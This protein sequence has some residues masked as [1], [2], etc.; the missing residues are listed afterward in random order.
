MQLQEEFTEDWSTKSSVVR[1][2]E[3]GA[4]IQTGFIDGFPKAASG[5]LHTQTL[6]L[7]KDLGTVGT[8]G[9][10]KRYQL[11]RPALQLGQGALALSGIVID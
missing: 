6:L 1:G 2:Q 3:A 7:R 9:L 11:L 8:L 10:G 4:G 5:S